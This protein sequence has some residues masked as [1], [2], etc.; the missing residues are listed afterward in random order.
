M[1]TDVVKYFLELVCIDSESR[2]ERKVADKLKADLA[3]LGAQVFEDEAFLEHG[4]NAGNVFAH[5]AGNPEKEPILFCAHMDTV[6]PGNGIKPIITDGVIHTDGSTILGSDDKSGVAEIMVG[7]KRVIDSGA[8]HAPIEVLFTICEEI[9]LLGARSFDK[10][11]I[12]A[13][14]GYAFD[15]HEVGEVIIGA[16]SAEKFEII[17]RGKEAHAG[18]EPENGINALRVASEAIAMM[19][20]GRIDHESTCNMGKISGGIATNIVPN[21]IVI[22][23]EARSHDNSKLDRIV[24]EVKQALDTAVQRY[25]LPHG[26]ASYEFNNSRDYVAFSIAEDHPVVQLAKK[27]LIGLGIEPK[28][29]KGGGGSD[30][31]IFNLAGIS[32]VIC[33]SGM[34]NVHT[35]RERIKVSELEKGADLVEAMII[36]YSK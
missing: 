23:G 19:P 10:S 9:G 28:I 15:S 13:K 6:R 34:D 14:L 31:N 26:H 11:K 27:A 16:P 32:M 36:A 35:V 2:N 5:F 24:A 3:A 12:K 30:A 1:H 22:N 20:N 18:V 8:D 25:Q 7:I 17:V 21:R 4:G 33:G 29:K